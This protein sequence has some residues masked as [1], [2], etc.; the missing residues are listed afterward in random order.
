MY[1]SLLQKIVLIFFSVLLINF[2][3]IY[4]LTKSVNLEANKIENSFSQTIE[5]NQTIAQENVV[6]SKKYE[7]VANKIQEYVEKKSSKNSNETNITLPSLDTVQIKESENNSTHS[8]NAKVEKKVDNSILLPKLAIIM[9]DV[10]FYRHADNI[11]RLPFPITP[12]IFPPTKLF[13]HTKEIAED[14][15]YYMVHFPMEAEN[16]SNVIENAIKVSDSKKV[17]KKRIDKVM[18]DF[19]NAIAINNHTGSKFTCDYDSM[20]DFFSILQAY[21]VSFID[22]KTTAK[23]QC[24]SAGKKYNKKVLQRDIFLDNERDIPYIK[25]Q[26]K[27]AVRIAKEHGEAIAIC[28]PREKTFQALKDSDEILKDVKLVYINELL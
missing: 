18:Q 17:L 11:K 22:S 4:F 13:P 8:K 28:H 9:D 26:L 1:N 14:L 12:S 23:T 15:G 16:Y 10:S 2:T 6:L 20:S 27:E 19:P 25:S 7:T 21:D 24:V 3:S 5:I